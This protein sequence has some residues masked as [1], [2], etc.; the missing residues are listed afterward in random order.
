MTNLIKVIVSD[1][2]YLIYTRFNSKI[3][4]KNIPAVTP[5]SIDGGYVGRSHLLINA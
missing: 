2:R 1:H 3:E 4:A 5:I